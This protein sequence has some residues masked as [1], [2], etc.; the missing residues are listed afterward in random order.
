MPKAG[1]VKITV[2]VPEDLLH[3]AMEVTGLGITATVRLALDTVVK[4]AKTRRRLM[5]QW[6][7]RGLRKRWSQ[8]L[9]AKRPTIARGRRYFFRGGWE[10]LNSM[11]LARD[12]RGYL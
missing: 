8:G 9:N 12:D 1:M 7:K 10:G 2:M 4:Q 11:R 3:R 6:T 5:L